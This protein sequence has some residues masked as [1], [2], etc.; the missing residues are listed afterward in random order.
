ME[1]L[2]DGLADWFVIK[3]TKDQ[4]LSRHLLSKNGFVAAHA[5][6]VGTEVK[7]NT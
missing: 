4:S 2:K 1:N 3:Y 7:V 5:T 6:P